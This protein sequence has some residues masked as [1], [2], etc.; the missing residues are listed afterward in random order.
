MSEHMSA[1]WFFGVGVGHGVAWISHHLIGHE[2]GNIELLGE[3]H[4]A[5]ENFAED[6]LA[7]RKL[8]STSIVISETRHNRIN[9]E[10]AV[11]GF[12]H[13]SGCHIQ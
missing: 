8:A 7:F 1:D 2:Y 3:L 4:N 12:D 11:R 6:L 13:Q 9:D 10:K 5:A